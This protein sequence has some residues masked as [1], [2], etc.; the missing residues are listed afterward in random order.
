MRWLAWLTCCVLGVSAHGPLEPA[1]DKGYAI[2]S[3]GILPAELVTWSSGEVWWGVFA[4]KTGFVL[5]PATLVVTPCQDPISDDPG[6]LT[7]KETAVEGDRRPLFLVKGLKAPVAGPLLS[8]FNGSISLLPGNDLY[9][10]IGGRLNLQFQSKGDFVPREDA[11]KL[12]GDIVNYQL[13]LSGGKEVGAPQV[14]A[15]E[16]ALWSDGIPSVQWVGD[17]DRDGLL[18]F[19]IN[20]GMHYA[21]AKTQL[22]LSSE[23]GNTALAVPVATMAYSGC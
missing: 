4:D 12:Y 9:F 15:R 10:G 8:V 13:T 5:A 19:T 20:L 18:D 11:Q 1:A 22:F 23:A 7:G 16:D 2:V 6:T 17:L 21:A 14:L 3:C